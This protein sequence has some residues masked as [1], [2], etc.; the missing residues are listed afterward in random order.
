MQTTSNILASPALSFTA[1]TFGAAVIAFNSLDMLSCTPTHL[2]H[3]GEQLVE[4][5][6]ICPT[7]LQFFTSLALHFGTE[8]SVV[9]FFWGNI[10][11]LFFFNAP[12]S[13]KQDLCS[14]LASLP[15]LSEAVIV[16]ILA[17][18]NTELLG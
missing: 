14:T 12:L 3:V 16:M 5:N 6:C 13:V 10:L 18:G 15:L 7:S 17:S 8:R 11:A 1:E 9:F 4:S 2:E